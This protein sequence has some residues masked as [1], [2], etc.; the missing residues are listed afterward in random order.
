M[1]T[2]GSAVVINAT[3]GFSSLFPPFGD[4]ALETDQIPSQLLQF[5]PQ[6]LC[7]LEPEQVACFSLL[8][9]NKEHDPSTITS[10]GRFI[11][12]H[13]WCSKWFPPQIILPVHKT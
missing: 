2:F 1:E 4:V 13:V 6:E 10:C 12:Q 7:S 11:G 5:E 9:S 8:L 3:S